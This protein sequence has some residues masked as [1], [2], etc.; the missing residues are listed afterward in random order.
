M[1]WV[2]A[3]LLTV[4]GVLLAVFGPLAGEP[5]GTALFYIGL[6]VVVVGGVLLLLALVRAAGGPPGAM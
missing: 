5:V 2:Q 1:N 3:F 6:I 4:A